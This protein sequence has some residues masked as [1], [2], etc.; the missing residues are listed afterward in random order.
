LKSPTIVASA[1]ENT[2]PG[3]LALEVALRI[4]V[5]RR[6]RAAGLRAEK[7]IPPPTRGGSIRRVRCR[8]PGG[9]QIPSSQFSSHTA[10]RVQTNALLCRYVSRPH[11]LSQIPSAGWIRLRP[12]EWKSG[13]GVEATRGG[14]RERAVQ[15]K[16]LAVNAFRTQHQSID[17]QVVRTT[18]PRA[19]VP[20][21]S[22]PNPASNT[23]PEMAERSPRPRRKCARNIPK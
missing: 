1:R 6:R 16:L 23:W 21:F 20:V 13:K 9:F 12:I 17:G 8:S 10:I 14:W 7:V 5:F 3:G 11:S 4:A 15:R 22:D 18:L 19:V 2:K